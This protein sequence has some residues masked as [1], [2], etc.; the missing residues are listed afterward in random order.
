MDCLN[1]CSLFQLAKLKQFGI[2]G[3]SS[4]GN[5]RENIGRA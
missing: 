3:G 2:F 4:L 5:G 1:F